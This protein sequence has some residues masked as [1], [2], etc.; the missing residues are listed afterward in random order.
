MRKLIIFGN[1]ASG[2]ST[3]AKYLSNKENLAHLDLDTLA[4]L[5]CLPPQRTP[6]NECKI[7][8]DS[9]IMQHNAWVIEGC[10]SDL[11]ALVASAANEV[12]F[13]NLD[14]EACVENAKQRPWEAHKYASKTAQDKNLAML[15]NWIRDYK[16]R[17]DEFSF[18][19]HQ[20]FYENFS[21]KKVQYVDR[22]DFNSLRNQSE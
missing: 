19:A 10:Y 2:K 4:W 16:T 14:I 5:D 8:I 17:V 21:G 18:H 1:S 13:I 3:L 22:V 12:I 6:L 9:F 11:L 15:I 20:K 7:K